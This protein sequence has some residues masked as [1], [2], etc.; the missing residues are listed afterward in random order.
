MLIKAADDQSA[1]LE[2]LER[3][4]AGTGADARQATRDLRIRRA[5]IK[6]ER[7]SAYLI[8]FHFAE[9]PNWAVIHDL[10]IEH[11][12]RVA[13]IDHLLINRWLDF[14]VLESKHFH[15]GIKITEDGEF[16]QWNAYRK[17]FEGMASPLEQNERHIEVLKDAVSRI[18]LPVRL[19]V[20]IPP[21]F[22]SLV[23]VASKARIDR[24]RK[25]DTG[26]VIKADQFK[27]RIWKDIDEESPLLGLFRTAAK[28][29]SKE[30][31]EGVARQMVALHRPLNRDA[32]PMQEQPD[33]TPPAP[34]NS[35][36]PRA[37]ASIPTPTPRPQAPEP[38]VVG[39]PSCNSCNGAD[40]SILYGR[41]GYYFKCGGCEGNTAIRF[42]CQPGH[43]PRLRKSGDEFYRDCKQCGSSDLFHR[44]QS[45]PA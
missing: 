40:G 41:Y 37:P 22:N 26:R 18:E 23:L 24:P 8:D 1:L 20:R 17:S 28:I 4:A 43:K 33:A 38:V 5:G 16:L 21:S 3:R 44:N 7:D 35:A 36:R 29:V 39:A 10:R 2:D 27:K 32:K 42:S 45:A 30:T 6:G 31:L 9:A 11:G 15:A 25:F 14:Y 12:N 13:Q 19:G 34:R